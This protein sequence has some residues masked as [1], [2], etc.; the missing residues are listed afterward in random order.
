MQEICNSTALTREELRM[1][2]LTVKQRGTLHAGT[3][4][5]MALDYT[6]PSIIRL[7]TS[8]TTSPAN[9]ST[10]IFHQL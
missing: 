1:I 5:R 4:L 2:S 6:T 7:C 9:S 3:L 10:P 8:A